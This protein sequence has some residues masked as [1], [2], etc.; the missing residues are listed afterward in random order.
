MVRAPQ[1]SDPLTHGV[2]RSSMSVG[3]LVHAPS[4]RAGF[5]DLELF[6]GVARVDAR[7]WGPGVRFRRFGTVRGR[8]VQGR[9]ATARG[10]PA[11]AAGAEGDGKTTVAAVQAELRKLA[12]ESFDA[13]SLSALG[14]WNGAGLA[15]LSVVRVRGSP[16]LLM[17][18]D[19]G[20]E[21]CAQLNHL[22]R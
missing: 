19:L 17:A 4:T 22:I 20:Q 18:Q 7:P 10:A 13:S 3:E 21:D 14:A 15:E 6:S 1:D 8:A 5:W 12:R 16:A 2:E 11:R 9:R